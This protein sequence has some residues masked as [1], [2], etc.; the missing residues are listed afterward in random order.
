MTIID[1]RYYPLS[2]VGHL[3]GADPPNHCLSALIFIKK[4]QSRGEKEGQIGCRRPSGTDFMST[5][6]HASSYACFGDK[7]DLMWNFKNAFLFSCFKTNAHTRACFGR[8]IS[9]P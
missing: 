3:H 9:V 4:E 6:Q 7:G 1:P 2:L 5:G 8:G